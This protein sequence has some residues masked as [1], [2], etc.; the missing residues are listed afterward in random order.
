LLF[1]FA[2][3]DFL[4]GFWVSMQRWDDYGEHLV[5][6]QALFGFQSFTTMHHYRP[7]VHGLDSSIAWPAPRPC[8]TRS[9]RQR[10]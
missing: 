6:S 9:S 10:G 4:V 3:C 1:S 2:T 8:R 5:E 7:A